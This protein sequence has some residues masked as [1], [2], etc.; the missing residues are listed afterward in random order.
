MN[1]RG[2]TDIVPWLRGKRFWPP[3]FIGGHHAT[4]YL[5][6][7]DRQP[8]RRS[9]RF[10]RAT[11]GSPIGGSGQLGERRRDDRVA[12]SKQLW[13]AGRLE[14]VSAAAASSSD[15]LSGPPQPVGE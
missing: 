1:R 5:D 11:N 15:V 12:G 7:G 9:G 10:V 14:G 2:P 8:Y 3:A 13:D 4:S 6:R